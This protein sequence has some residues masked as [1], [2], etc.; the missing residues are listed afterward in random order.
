[1]QG[2]GADITATTIPRIQGYLSNF[3]VVQARPDRPPQP[4]LSG[5]YH[6]EFACVAGEWRFADRLILP[7]LFGDLSQHMS[8]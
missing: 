1:M 3:T 8:R 4:V 7:E 2:G 5:Q 6:D